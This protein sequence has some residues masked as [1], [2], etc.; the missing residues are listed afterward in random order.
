MR[1]DDVTE[2]SGDAKQSQCKS[3]KK[4]AYHAPTLVYLGAVKELTKGFAGSVP[5][6]G[7]IGV[8]PGP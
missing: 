2:A 3:P 1:N 6:A 4:A 7:G 5:D 8:K